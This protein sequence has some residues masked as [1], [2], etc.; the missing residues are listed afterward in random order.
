M[1]SS[2]VMCDDTY[3]NKLWSIVAQGMFSLC[4]V[5]RMD[6]G[7]V[8]KKDLADAPRTSIDARATICEG[9]ALPQTVMT[10][11]LV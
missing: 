8:G 3:F 4:E 1:I 2:K 9:Y 6:G 7:G 5:N 10:T 11:T